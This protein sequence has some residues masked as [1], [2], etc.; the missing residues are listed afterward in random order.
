MRVVRFFPNF[1]FSEQPMND[2]AAMRPAFVFPELVSAA[3]NK[4]CDI[5]NGHQVVPL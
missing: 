3:A 5:D 4:I 1:G 2:V